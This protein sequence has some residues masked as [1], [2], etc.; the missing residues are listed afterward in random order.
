[1]ARSPREVPVAHGFETTTMAKDAL[2][3]LLDDAGWPRADAER[4][5]FTGRDDL[6]SC[7]FQAG[8]ATGVALS[9]AGLALPDRRA[10][11][12]SISTTPR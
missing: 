4:V 10:A 3:N 6:Y 11:S 9:A 2:R 1:M 8:V 7:R 12:A 5:T